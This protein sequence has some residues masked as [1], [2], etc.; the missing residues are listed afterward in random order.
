VD[1]TQGAVMKAKS[2]LLGTYVPRAKKS[3]TT[4][5]SRIPFPDID[6]SESTEASK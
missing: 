3:T 4:Y 2:N 6:G 1:G 5:I